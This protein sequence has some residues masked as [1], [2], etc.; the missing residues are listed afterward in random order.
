MEISEIKA[1]DA[2]IIKTYY[3]GKLNGYK[4]TTVE[5]VLKTK[6]KCTNKMEFLT[7]ELWQ[8]M[9]YTEE[10]FKKVKE[11]LVINYKKDIKEKII[12][13]IKLKPLLLQ[14]YKEVVEETE[15]EMTQ[16]V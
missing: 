15:K 11:E 1:G 7:N 16:S 8:I 3:F 10:N 6:I 5:K 13:D 14:A 9:Q 12:P 4:I 2:I